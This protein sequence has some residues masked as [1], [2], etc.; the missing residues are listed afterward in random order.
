MGLTGGR[1]QLLKGGEELV[2][3]MMDL[4]LKR[5]QILDFTIH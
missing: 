3:G 4:A 5:S 1:G 2:R